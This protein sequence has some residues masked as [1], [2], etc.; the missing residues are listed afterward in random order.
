V[1]Q[2]CAAQPLDFADVLDSDDRPGVGAYVLHDHRGV[3]TV[4]DVSRATAY[5]GGAWGMVARR[6][7]KRS[8]AEAGRVLAGGSRQWG[9]W[10]RAGFEAVSAFFGGGVI[11]GDRL[12]AGERQRCGYRAGGFFVHL[13][14]S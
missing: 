5:R 14:R 12:V 1:G 3:V 7:L 2:R 4:V 11:G 10:Q 9:R 8:T 13:G 6:A